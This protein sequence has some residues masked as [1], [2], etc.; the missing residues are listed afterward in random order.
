MRQTDAALDHLDLRSLR[1]LSAML[2]M[3]SITRAGEALGLS[4]PAASRA[5]AH[6]R[7]AIGDPLLVRIGSGY[8]LTPRA[9]GLVPLTITAIAAVQRVFTPAGFDPQTASGMIRVATTDYGAAIVLPGLVRR[10]RNEA[11]GLRLEAAPWS[12]TT[13][14]ALEGGGL[15]L[16]LY[17]EADL[18]DSYRCRDLFREGYACLVADDHPVLAQR[19]QDGT[20][21]MELLAGLPRAVMLYPDGRTMAPDDVLAGYGPGA[22]AF[23][24]TPYFLSG[25]LA[26]VGTDLAL[27]LPA[28]AAALVYRL[29]G[30]VVLPLPELAG[31]T[32][33]L[34]WHIRTDDDP[35][36]RWVRT[37]AAASNWP[38]SK[39]E[40][41]KLDWAG[42]EANQTEHSADT[43][44]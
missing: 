39:H 36:L 29:G 43:G 44:S 18:P 15:E 5:V 10:L 14:S 32:Y 3:R 20:V 37:L 23:F 8:A 30:T 41:T 11:P 27:C 26:V 34:I 24:G 6:L 33:R 4:Q 42:S 19:R 13:L 9:E 21:A 7:R 25:P 22:P 2:E 16:A 17:A 1:L 28:R 35:M 12:A 38:F 40:L 31:F